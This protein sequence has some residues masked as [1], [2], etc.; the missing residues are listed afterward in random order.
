MSAK[1]VL[2]AWLPLAIVATALIGTL[3][4][5]V[6]QSYRM[7]ANDLPTRLAEDAAAGLG[8]GLS[9]AAVVG[10]ATVAAD[11]TI[12]FGSYDKNLYA[13]HPDGTLKWHYLTEG[14][15]KS[16]PAL[17]ANGTVFVNTS[18]DGVAA[19]QDEALY[20][21]TWNGGATGSMAWKKLLGYTGVDPSGDQMVSTPV[22]GADGFHS[23][24]ITSFWSWARSARAERSAAFRTFFGTS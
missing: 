22:L 23:W 15:I 13:L 24:T 7:V 1:R 10:S 20:A 18:W 8:R 9:P 2:T 12:Y 14:Y 17:S 19:G 4:I 21:I 5:V 6:Q 3:Y 11:G 16:T